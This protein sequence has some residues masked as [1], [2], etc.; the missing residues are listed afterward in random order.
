MRSF[1]HENPTIA[2]GLGLPLLLV[3]IFLL[4][5]GIPTLLVDPPQHDVLYAT[6][7]YNDQQG[8]Q[9]SVVD[10]KVLVSY[11]GIAQ[12]GRTPRLWRHHSKT[13]AV[14]EIA[15][16]LPPSLTSLGAKTVE[17][18]DTLTS[19]PINV[20]DLAGLVVDSSSIA[21][22]GYEFSTGSD[23]YSGNIFGGLFYSS[24]YRHQAAL[25]KDGRSVR[26]PNADNYY[27]RKNT[28]FIGWVVSP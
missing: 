27:Y 28:R 9:I 18:R 7:Y 5:S 25:S 20:P 12:G 2:F 23:R 15:I 26:L 24:R 10:Q 11:R 3:V 13:G 6:E 22:D 4:I 16:I 21:P 19:T 8:V 17:P 14:Q 1:L